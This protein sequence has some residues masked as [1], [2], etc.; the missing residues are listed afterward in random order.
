MALRLRLLSVIL[1][2]L[3]LPP[4]QATD[5]PVS[6]VPS[7][8]PELSSP[9]GRDTPLTTDQVY[10]MTARA[11]AL[12]GG[13]ESVV[14]DTARL[15]VIKPNISIARASGTG[16]VTD[17]RVVRAVALLVHEASPQA[18]ILIAE[19]AGGWVSPAMADCSFVHLNR[20]SDRT[21]RLQDGFEIAGHRATVAE[22]QGLGID[23]DVHDLNFDLAYKM[24]VPGG[25]LLWDEYELASSIIDADVWIN[26]PVAKTHGAKITCCLK[27]HFGIFP[28][29]VYGWNK[30]RGTETHEGIPHWPRLMDESWVDLV[31][32]SQVDLNVVDMLQGTEGGAFEGTP[33]RSNIVLAGADPIATDL[34]V[35][36]L[37]GFNPDDFEFADL[38]AQRGIGPGSIDGV[39]TRGGD[40]AVLS[41]R[42]AKASADYGGDW[43]EHAQYGM[44]PRRWILLG[45][46][47]K[48]H[49]FTAQQIAALAPTSGESDWSEVVWF[50]FDKIDLDTHFDDPVQVA[51]YAFTHF[52]MA[53]SDSVRF[54][55]GS[56]EALTVW[57]DGEQIYT[58][59][60][61]RRHDMGGDKIPGYVEAGEHRLLIRAEQG[62][63]RFD[64]SFNVCE[65]IDDLRFAG[66]RYPGVRYYQAGGGPPMGSVQVQAKQ[67]WSPWRV[68]GVEQT[69]T[70]DE[71]PLTTSR[72]APDSLLIDAPVARSI[73]LLDVIA[74]QI[75]GIRVWAA[76]DTVTPILF[77]E[78]PFTMGH[79]G[80]GKEGWEAEYGLPLAR[81][82]KWAGLSYWLSMANGDDESTK[83]VAG[84]L[85]QGRVPITGLRGDGW[86]QLNGYRKDGEATLVHSLRPDTTV[87]HELS[88]D[89]TWGPLPGRD[90]LELPVLVVE[91]TSDPLSFDDWVDS[92]A[93]AT[94]EFARQARTEFD[95]TWGKRGNPSGLAG[96]D[97]WM[98]EW[99]RQPWTTQWASSDELRNWLGR[100]GRGDYESKSI[101][102]GFAA[103]MYER[104]AQGSGGERQRLLSEA[105]DA[106]TDGSEVMAQIHAGLPRERS[107]ALTEEDSL[108][109]ASIATL[110]PLARQVRAAERRALGALAELLGQ[111]SLPEAQEDPLLRRHDG[112]VLYR[113][114][115]SFSKGVYDLRLKKK[116]FTRTL[117]NG[118]DV[119]DEVIDVERGPRRKKGWQVALEVVA[120]GGRYHI[121]Q[122]PTAD[123]DWTLIIRVDDGWTDYD[124]ATSLVVWEVPAQ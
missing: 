18:R 22:L 111:A 102:R 82:M 68:G 110:Q 53:T 92:T 2:L 61:R 46:L 56:D 55:I 95:E 23:I 116:K 76:D 17:A 51:V 78:I 69:F 31:L 34:V 4:A 66:N 112:R 79:V 25:G 41:H 114:Q 12:I 42:F 97:A 115:T 35:A 40:P 26:V 119:N 86:T 21:E 20:G 64:F 108:A 30:A 10:D 99:E 39:D 27:N 121:A 9:T 98:I 63:G 109:L 94:L 58:H 47:E 24:Q 57:I 48:D 11:L 36:Q 52:T 3:T 101:K 93:A 32:M 96:W 83:V 71:D 106:Y 16:I 62:R 37:M 65:P 124:N 89:G 13:M 120:G 67:A 113:W 87:W 7:D 5:F 72:H 105:A 15:V 77:S 81:L 6:V 1:V 19:G 43:G 75:P 38:G 117:I 14:K 107:G 91:A 33:K 59:E 70:P 29:R 90:W 88:S 80:F 45:P 8:D 104:A 84:W 44:G 118:R 85:A 49:A 60:G 74:T 28:G 50:G 103:Q 73:A 54:W 123:N 100:M 122:R